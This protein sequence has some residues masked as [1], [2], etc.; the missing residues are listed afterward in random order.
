MGAFDKTRPG[1]ASAA[2]GLAQRCLDE[3]AMYAMQR[4]TFGTQIANHQAVQFMLA[5]MATGIELSRLMVRKS[6]WELDQVGYMYFFSLFS[7]IFRFLHVKN[8]FSLFV[9]NLSC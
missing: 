6:A 7:F 8:Y 3:A 2:V 1:V 4:K 9:Y 5:E